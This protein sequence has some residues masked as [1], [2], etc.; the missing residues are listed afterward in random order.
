MVEISKTNHLLWHTTSVEEI[1]NALLGDQTSGISEA[2]AK[3]RLA[4][5]GLNTLTAEKKDPFWEAFL[6]DL[7]ESMSYCMPFGVR[8]LTQSRFSWSSS[9][10]TQ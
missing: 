2:E 1:T 4:Q 10:S 6:E 8:S 7:R 5:A 3:A 9:L